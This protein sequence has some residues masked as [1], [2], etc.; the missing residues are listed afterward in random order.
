MVAHDI[1]EHGSDFAARISAVGVNWATV[2]ENIATGYPTPASVVAAWMASTGHCQ[3]ILD[4]EFSEIGIGALPRGIRPY[5]SRPGSWTQDFALPMGH[6]P[7]SEN[8]RP[9]DGCPYG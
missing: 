3:N 5:G 7:P 8:F 9:A 4:P 6:R 1:F 2:G